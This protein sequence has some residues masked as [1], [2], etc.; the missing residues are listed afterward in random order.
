MFK[1]VPVSV[2][3]V[4]VYGYTCMCEIHIG[5]FTHMSF[6]WAAPFVPAVRD[7]LRKRC[8]RTFNGSRLLRVRKGTAGEESCPG[9]GSPS[10]LLRSLPGRVYWAYFF[11]AF[12]VSLP[13]CQLR[14][15][16]PGRPCPWADRDA[17]P[18]PGVPVCPW[19]SGGS[20]GSA[21]PVAGC[22]RCP[23][24]SARALAPSPRTGVLGC[25]SST[26]WLTALAVLGVAA[27]VRE[28]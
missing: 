5:M 25:S 18:A 9:P 1:Y 6:S 27:P 21:P 26:C 12:V 2:Y 15:A 17:D 3:N 20:W 13:L 19:G 23:R 24:R 16:W 14:C 4:C 8:R 7:F 11:K 22:P 10:G 28:G